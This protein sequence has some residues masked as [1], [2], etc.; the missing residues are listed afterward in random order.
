MPGANFPASVGVDTLVGGAIDGPGFSLGEADLLLG[1]EVW[2]FY[3]VVHV[4][5]GNLIVE[6]RSLIKP[7]ANYG[8]PT[9]EGGCD[10]KGM[11][12][13]RVVF[14]PEWG[15]PAQ[16]VIVDNVI[17]VTSLRGKRLWRIPIDGDSEFTGTPVDFYPGR[18]GRLRAIA[19]VP[20]ADELWVG[21]SDLGYGKDKI[22]RVSLK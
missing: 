16:L 4:Q 22:L 18:F 14:H 20:G 10:V 7:G 17:Y 3:G 6:P 8:F 19:K 5:G 1:L 11:T 2:D 21:T 13:P 12:T 15:V 9:C